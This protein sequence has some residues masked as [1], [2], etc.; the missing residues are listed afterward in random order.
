MKGAFLLILPSLLGACAGSASRE[1]RPFPDRVY[2]VEEKLVRAAIRDAMKQAIFPIEREDANAIVG[3]R[4]EDAGF[5]WRLTVATQTENSAVNVRTQ[6]EIDRESNVQP[7]RSVFRNA[8]EAG[9]DDEVA[10]G[11]SDTAAA[12]DRKEID[13]ARSE[14]T[15]NRERKIELISTRVERF[16][17][18]L[19][20]RIPGK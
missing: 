4:V 18:D 9:V 12:N 10:R 13:A 7:I 15:E 14:G 2:P 16:L 1:E 20:S 3:A 11:A 8:A 17:I 19:D 5:S 6:L